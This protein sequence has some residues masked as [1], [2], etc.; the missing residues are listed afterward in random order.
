V[1]QTMADQ[2]AV[3]IDNAR[4]FVDAEA[5]LEEMEAIHR[6]YLGQAWA[7]Y[8]HTRAVSGYEQT[9]SGMR[10][11]GPLGN[12]VLP[13]TQQAITEK[14]PVVWNGDGDTD[15]S[16]STLA[17]PIMLRDQPIGAIGFKA[18]EGERRWSADDVA[19]VEAIAGQLAQAIESLRL[20]EETQRRAAYER[21]VSEITGRV[22]ASLDPDTI[23]KTTVQEMGRALGA[24]LATV[25]ITGPGNDNDSPPAEEM[26]KGK[27]EI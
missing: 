22:W 7:E 19:L 25:E 14:H 24:K 13:E 3:A 26:V 12:K 27:K 4:L 2:V 8:A 11:F 17:A 9:E 10:P 21:S 20:F 23:L 16:P 5:A 18:A 15:S 1:M 6:R